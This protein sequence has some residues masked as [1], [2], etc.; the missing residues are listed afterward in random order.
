MKALV[1]QVRDADDPPRSCPIAGVATA[2][3]EKFKGRVKAARHTATNTE[4]RLAEDL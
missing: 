1:I 3:A 2:P 4:F